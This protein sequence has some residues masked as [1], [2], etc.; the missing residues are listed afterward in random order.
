[1]SNDF[2]TVCNDKDILLEKNDDDM[3]RININIIP[4]KSNNY[5]LIDIVTENEL[6]NLLYELN[7][8][9]IEEYKLT[10]VNKNT[11]NVFIKVKSSSEKQI[12]DELKEIIINMESSYQLLNSNECIVYCNNLNKSTVKFNNFKIEITC[13]LNKTNMKIEFILD[14]VNDLI[15]TYIALYIKKIF[16]R[17]SKYLS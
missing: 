8:D 9:N 14:D 5:T 2:Y 16:Y 13:E 7:R 4:N 3:Y 11:Q 17:L 1:M 10:N 15:S 6:W 12:S